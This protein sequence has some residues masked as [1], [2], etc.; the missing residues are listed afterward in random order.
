MPLINPIH[1]IYGLP[2]KYYLRNIEWADE[3]WH[4]NRPT[5][6]TVEAD[7]HSTIPQALLYQY[8]MAVT[9][10]DIVPN[11][12]V[13]LT[14]SFDREFGIHA[15][16]RDLNIHPLDIDSFSIEHLH[17]QLK[18]KNG[19]TYTYDL[20]KSRIED[21]CMT[22]TDYAY[23]R[24]TTYAWNVNRYEE[25]DSTDNQDGEPCIFDNQGNLRRHLTPE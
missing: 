17:V 18:M 13:C 8:G 23:P 11:L 3:N 20:M 6:A 16:C 24:I 21:L 4:G 12:T 19:D 22:D 2:M 14:F 25:V 1:N 10:F 7:S 9:D 15:I 5:H